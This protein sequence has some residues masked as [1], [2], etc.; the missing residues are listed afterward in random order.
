MHATKDADGAW[1]V[2]LC[3]GTGLLDQSEG[4]LKYIRDALAHPGEGTLS[5]F[6]FVDIDPG[7]GVKSGP[8]ISNVRLVLRGSNRELT[9]R[10]DL[11]GTYRFE[12]VP[13]GDYTLTVELPRDYTPVPPKH[14]AIGK[15]ACGNHFF[16]TTKR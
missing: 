6:A 10:T 15:G 14:V 9:T 13:P 12:M 7:T 2:S 4:P 8:A 5:G 3:G 11:K 1:K 16:W